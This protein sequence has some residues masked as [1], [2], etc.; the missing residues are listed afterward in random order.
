MPSANSMRPIVVSE[1]LLAPC[2][3]EP[4]VRTPT[5]ATSPSNR[6]FVACVVPWAMNTTSSGAIPS[7][8]MTWWRAWTIPA[9]TPS[10]AEWVVGT[11]ALP[12]TSKVVLS[13]ATASVKVPPTSIPIL[14]GMGSLVSLL[15]PE[16]G[17][18]G[19]GRAA[20]GP[21]RA[22]AGGAPSGGCR[23]GGAT[24][25]GCGRAGG[26]APWGSGTGRARAAGRRPAPCPADVA[27]RGRMGEAA[28]EVEERPQQDADGRH[29]PQV[30][31]DALGARVDIDFA[32]VRGP[33]VLR[34][35]GVRAGLDAL[36]GEE[37]RHDR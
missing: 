2:R 15:R 24:P 19:R 11:F 6:A 5:V 22:V 18:R 31:E 29:R 28:S 30:G 4:R 16:R 7:D 3:P 37:G 1:R 32:E 17:R 10:G 34:V 14:T 9:A 26:G 23:L 33:H 36:G 25:S 12:I 13:M 27:R 35:R 21:A 20:G 8:S